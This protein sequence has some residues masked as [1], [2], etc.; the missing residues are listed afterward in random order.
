VEMRREVISVP[1]TS[2]LSQKDRVVKSA[3]V[4]E[5]QAE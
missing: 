5:I 2:V 1:I 4:D 3:N